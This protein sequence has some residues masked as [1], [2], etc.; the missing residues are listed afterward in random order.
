M[1]KYLIIC[2]SFFLA[3]GAALADVQFTIRDGEGRTSTF[4]SN[5]KMA[6][7]E[8]KQMPS[9]VII[10][11][12]SGEFNMVDTERGEIMKTSMGKGGVVA[13]DS[14]I[15]VKLKDKG[16]G[17]KIAG[18]STRKYELIANGESCGT[19]YASRK[20]LK[21]NNVRAIF[22]SMRSMQQHTRSMRGGM[23]GMMSVCDQ[24]N[25]QQAGMIESSGVPMRMID[26]NGKLE[27]EVLAV[28]T[29]K[30]FAGN[31]YALP[32][33]M[34]VVDMSDKMN[35]AT[36]QTQQMKENMPDMDELMKQIQ[37]GGGQMT[38]EMQQQME[39]M[40]EMMK[41]LQQQSQ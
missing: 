36:Q 8:D 13:N 11:H 39:Q 6:R 33:D 38:E 23:S 31:H 35:E 26:Q 19:I 7:I 15:S 32:A 5:G 4:S 41:Q 12:A 17:P 27:S 29:N 24:A 3:S 34:K 30:K 2:L 25:M 16:G 37:Q 20:L 1:K 22:E 10:D 28:D 21:N 9:Y 40:Q 18:Y 14:K